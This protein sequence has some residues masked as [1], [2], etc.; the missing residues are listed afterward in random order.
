MA[1]WSSHASAALRLSSNR[2]SWELSSS[3]LRRDSVRSRPRCSRN[4]NAVHHMWVY[5]IHPWSGNASHPPMPPFCPRNIRFWG[6]HI[7]S[8]CSIPSAFCLKGPRNSLFGGY[9]TAGGPPINF[10]KSQV[11]FSLGEWTWNFRESC[12]L[13]RLS[14]FLSDPLL[15][16]FRCPSEVCMGMYCYHFYYLWSHSS[17]SY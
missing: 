15:L 5:R 3:R 2:N 1:E 6:S 7:Q 12:W 10:W 4:S 13:P 9:G 11:Y 16:C 14:W 8:I 17:H